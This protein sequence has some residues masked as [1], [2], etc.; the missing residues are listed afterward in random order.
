MNGKPLLLLSLMA[1]VAVA[2]VNIKKR[3]IHSD[4]SASTEANEEVSRSRSDSDP[5][6]ARSSIKNRPASHKLS[7]DD[8]AEQEA[9]RYALRKLDQIIIPIVQFENTSVE[10]ALDYLRLRARE[11]DPELDNRRRGMGY[12]NRTQSVQATGE[13]DDES[14]SLDAMSETNTTFMNP[15]I[16]MSAK[17]IP[18]RQALDMICTQAGLT[19][20]TSGGRIVVEPVDRKPSS[21]P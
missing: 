17:N 3:L 16:T 4:S 15:G 2:L 8:K 5:E 19:W 14:D 21:S 7:E 12:M 9:N 13:N 6:H 20:K 10:E 11:L 18:L 1:I